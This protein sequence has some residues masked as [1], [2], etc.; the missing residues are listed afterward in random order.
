[1]AIA[2]NNFGRMLGLAAIS[3]GEEGD[4]DQVI[5][6]AHEK[7]GGPEDDHFISYAPEGK[8]KDIEAAALRRICDMILPIANDQ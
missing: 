1:M 2:D 4:F 8:A 7:G 5:V 3:L 6:Y